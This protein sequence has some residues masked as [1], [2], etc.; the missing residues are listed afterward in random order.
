MSDSFARKYV[1]TIPQ[2]LPRLPPRRPE[3]HKGDYGLAL[4][5]G[6]SVGM[7]GAAA[8]AGLAALRSGAGL[9]RLAV[10]EPCRN[11][12]AGFEPS[13]MVVGLPSDAE[14]RL[15]L[16]ALDRI[17][18]LAQKATAVALGP[19][20]GRSEELTPLV[21]H[22]YARMERPMVLDAD[23]LNALAESGKLTVRPP[24]PRILTPHPGEFSRLSGGKKPIEAERAYLTQQYAAHWGVILILKGYQTCISNGQQT[25]L[26]PTGNPGMA[27][28]GTGDV[29]T[30]VITALL[31]QGLAPYDAARLGV[32]MHGLA[33]D[34]AA[35]EL[36]QVSLIA[37]DLIRYLPTAFQAVQQAPP[38]G[39]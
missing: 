10:P 13:Y 23:G 34:L 8:L 16:T 27:T 35:A 15:S 2:D 18:S 4:I 24:A 20:L 14:G 11:L 21:G 32:Y 29:L 33:G 12:V 17:E 7:A 3:S 1:P 25:W 31:A 9:V 26:N 36:G 6:G 22:L 28:G 38:E 37:S 39:D 30:G 5:V 19:G